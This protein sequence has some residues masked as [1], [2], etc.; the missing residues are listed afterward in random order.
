MEQRLTRLEQAFI[1]QEEPTEDKLSD[2]SESEEETRRIPCCGGFVSESDSEPE[3]YD[4]GYRQA[5]NVVEAKDS[6]NEA[7]RTLP[8]DC[9]RWQKRL[10]GLS[11][12]MSSIVGCYCE[13][14]TKV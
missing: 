9:K 14:C 3:L 7:T 1:D 8:C 12:V 11:S 10:D 13:N 4:L 2:E 5:P 6:F